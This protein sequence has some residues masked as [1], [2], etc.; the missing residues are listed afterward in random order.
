[1]ASHVLLMARKMIGY[2]SLVQKLDI[3]FS[4]QSKIIIR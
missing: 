1:L 3:D 4:R 2:T